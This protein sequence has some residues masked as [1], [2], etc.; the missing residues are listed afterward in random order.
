MSDKKRFIILY[1]DGKEYENECKDRE[2]AER[3][4]AEAIEYMDGDNW[5]DLHIVEVDE[6]DYFGI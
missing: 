2:D 1:G 4:L 3:I 5:C 6:E